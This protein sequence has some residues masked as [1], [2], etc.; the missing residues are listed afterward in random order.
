MQVDT[1]LWI[2]I[3]VLFL[4]FVWG[5]Y[6]LAYT[7]G[8]G[9]KKRRRPKPMKDREQKDWKQISLRLEKHIQELRRENI[10]WQ[11]R[12]KVLEKQEEIYKGRNAGL[13]EKLERE[14]V[15]Q[16]KEEED[17]GKKNKRLN[18]FKDE[19]KRL[20][21]KLEHEY[22]ELILVRRA[23]DELKETAE[24]Q[25]RQIK[26]LQAESQ[27]AKAQTDSYRKEML[28]LRAENAKLSQKHEDTQ[29]IAK[30]VHLKVK[31]ELRQVRKDLQ[32]LESGRP[33]E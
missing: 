23:N 14:R 20:E 6:F 1:S 15:W 9:R 2:T 13:Q 24:N 33:S 3:I 29:W 16:K 18:Q 31:E 25:D 5:L 27:K 8:K 26:Y 21:Q 19:V 22:S 28:G 12:V 32:R 7:T 4:I 11:K 30:S 10:N 17:L